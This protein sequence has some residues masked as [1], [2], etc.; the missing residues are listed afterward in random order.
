MGQKAKQLMRPRSKTFKEKRLPGFAE[1][2]F[3]CNCAL[4]E[5]QYVYLSSQKL[6]SSF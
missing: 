2:F 1:A 4:R 5:K 6:Q 3:P